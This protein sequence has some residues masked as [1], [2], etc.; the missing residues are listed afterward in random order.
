M[1]ASVIVLT[2]N[3]IEYLEHCLDAVLSQDYADLQVIVVDN[4]STDGSADLVA[5]RYPQVHLI[6]NN[7]NLGFSAGNNVGLRAAD[8]DVMVLLNQDTVV[9]VGWLEALV[10][11]FEQPDVGIAGCK[12][13]YPDGT[14]QHAGGFVYG[15]RVETEHTG[16]HEPDDG[17]FDQLR[18]ADFVTGAALAISGIVLNRVGLLDEGFS[19]VYY[20]DVDWCYT[21][22]EAGFRVVYVPAARLVHHETPT[23]RRES[24]EHKY[25]LHH[26]RLRFVFKHW[27]MKRLRE[28]FVPEEKAWA[29]GLGRTVEMMAARRAY[30]VTMLEAKAIAAFRTRPSG[31]ARGAD[32]TGEALALLRMLSDLRAACV[33]QESGFGRDT[34]LAAPPDQPARV[35]MIAEQEA[36]LPQRQTQFA[37]LQ[38]RRV[39]QEQPFASQVPVVGPLIAALRQK[40]HNLAVR[41]SLMPVIHQQNQFN[42]Q[43][44]D[45]FRL[46]MHMGDQLRIALQHTRQS[47]VELERDVTENT[48]DVAE[49]MRE[50]NEMAERLAALPPAEH[51]EIG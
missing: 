23:A 38:S 42:T 17:R 12:A 41:W 22:R 25:T 44:S 29:V 1:K 4:N 36:R 49:N 21:A 35:N 50:I 28:E 18:D 11:A 6:R 31:A 37:E 46:Q 10:A 34:E 39:I 47:I 2:W 9:Q 5:T 43:V 48:L 14:I 51:D 30:L 3:G 15:T 24:H 7:R 26:G 8:G 16:R 33:V 32:P 40:W 19:P 27:T 20:E 45:F 13:L